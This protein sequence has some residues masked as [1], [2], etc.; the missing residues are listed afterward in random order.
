MPDIDL[1][2]GDRL[3]AAIVEH[4]VDKQGGTRRARAHDRAAIGRGGRVH[5]PERPKQVLVGL[6]R[7]VIAVVEK[8]N[9]G[10]E[11]ERAGDQYGLVVGLAAVL[12]D[13][14]DISERGM[15]L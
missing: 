10:R 4:C 7:A 8:T 3:S 13:G 5:A 15:K 11:P 9:E 2:A 14:N 1:G 12:A 6:R